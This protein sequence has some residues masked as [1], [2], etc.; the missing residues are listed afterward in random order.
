MAVPPEP[1]P[2][3]SAK[4]TPTPEV[5]DKYADDGVSIEKVNMETA[6]EEMRGEVC[7]KIK[8]AIPTQNVSDTL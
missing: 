1:S 6:L 2:V 8:H 3:T 7:Y 4:W 5:V